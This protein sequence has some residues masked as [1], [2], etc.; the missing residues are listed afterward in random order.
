LQARWD[1]VFGGVFAARVVDSWYLF[2]FSMDDRKHKK[3]KNFDDLKVYQSSYELCGVVFKQ[4]L[5][6]L[7]ECEKWDLKDQLRR[8]CKAIPRLI[9]EGY[10]KKHQV[11]GFQK[12]LDDA[13]VESNE[14]IVGLRQCRDLYNIKLDICT[15]LVDRYDKVS[16]QT[17]KLALA[18]DKFTNFR[19]KEM[20]R[21]NATENE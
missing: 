18:W 3:I 16:R 7:P 15:Q 17:Y 21:E 8:S 14:S 19:K 11:K 4:I 5:P 13:L 6:L 10:A 12:Y 9:A 1:F 20:S 2:I